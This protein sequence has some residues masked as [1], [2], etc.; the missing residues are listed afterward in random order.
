MMSDDTTPPAIDPLALMREAYARGVEAWASAM[1]EV[2][3]SEEFAA[4]SGRMLALYAQ[5]QEAIRTA[6][7]LAAESIHMPTAED[8]A[9]LARLLANVERTV[10]ES[11]EAIIALGERL[12]GVE[13]AVAAVPADTVARLEERLAGAEA[14]IARIE[15]A[16]AASAAATAT[17]T[18]ATPPAPAA[19][20]AAAK[21]AAAKPAAKAAP[22]RATKATP[23][24]DAPK[25][26]TRAR[27]TPAS[28]K[29][30]G[31]D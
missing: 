29:A 31:D 13:K 17:D 26:A 25:R 8:I 19:K 10:D 16:L 6:S 2:V 28:R 9:S 12:A 20:P 11:N 14:A 21:P 24:T 15:S 18:P 27:T 22:K 3:G 7:R 1:E 5:Q 4:G 23:A 30:A